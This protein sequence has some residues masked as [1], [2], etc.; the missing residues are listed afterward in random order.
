[1]TRGAPAVAD[2][3]A[4]SS[5]LQF[6]SPLSSF[7]VDIIHRGCPNNDADWADFLAAFFGV[8][9][10]FHNRPFLDLLAFGKPMA[11]TSQRPTSFIRLAEV[12]Q[13]TGLSRSS[14]YAKIADGDFPAPINLGARAVAW[15]DHEIEDW[16]SERV[17]AS[18]RVRSTGGAAR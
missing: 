8:Y 6:F 18:R 17:S 16:M 10:L 15:I 1:V 4:A 12:K 11:P 5:G 7:L 14:I 2:A 13:R 9:H 3:R